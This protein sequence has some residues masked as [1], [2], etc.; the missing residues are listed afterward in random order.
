[1][2]AFIAIPLGEGTHTLLDQL[3]RSLRSADAEVRWV[4]IPS[5]H[6]TLKF[7]GEIE[8][9]LIGPIAESLGSSCGPEE[10]FTLEL[11]GLGAFPNLNSPR[12]VWCGVSGDMERLRALQR[13]AEDAA[14]EVGCPRD[15]RPFHPHLT[16]GRIMGSRNLHRLS[17]YIK[18]GSD[19]RAGLKV[20]LLQ[21][22]QSTLTPHG[23]VYEVLETVKLGAPN[24]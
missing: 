17:E 2:R 20:E 10:P 23:A 1:M 12:V 9:S 14:A 11:G 13:A 16:L 21:I 18:I 4:R 7:L 24:P 22:Y 8:E 3:Q 5:I 15:H 6:L 19:L